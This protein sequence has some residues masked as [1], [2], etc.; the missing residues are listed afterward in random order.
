[1]IADDQERLRAALRLLIQQEPGF[2]VVAEVNTPG[3]TLKSAQALQPDMVLLDWELDG[4][5]TP[6]LA[7][8]LRALPCAPLVLA[9]SSQ[10]EAEE[11]ALA[12]GADGFISK[13]NPPEC[14]RQAL[15]E[16]SHRAR[17]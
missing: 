7:A 5:H 3:E 12:A 15:R 10:P 16:T 9:L 14:V 2:E 13:G 17:R 6:V 11:A 4:A 1:M 8:A